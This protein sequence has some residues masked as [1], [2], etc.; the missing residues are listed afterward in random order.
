MKGKPQINHSFR[1]PEGAAEMPLGPCADAGILVE[2]NAGWRTMRPV[3]DHEK[4]V[5]CMICWTLCPDGVIGR[6]IDIDMDFC[7]G[8]GL[9][10]RECPR[11]AITMV[12]EGG[13]A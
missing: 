10:A 13:E 11:K 6:E 8:C 1:R 5:K 3:V 7:K 2:G 4:C 12:K 9:C